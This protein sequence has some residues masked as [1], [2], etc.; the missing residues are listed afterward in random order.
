MLKQKITQLH[1]GKAHLENKKQYSKNSSI[2]FDE[3]IRSYEHQGHRY[4]P[5]TYNQ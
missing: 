2:N 3:A 1:S 5:E 4:N